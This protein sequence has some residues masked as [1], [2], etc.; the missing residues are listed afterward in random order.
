MSFFFDPDR[1]ILAQIN[2]QAMPL[3]DTDALIE[4]CRGKKFILIG[5]ATHGTAEFYRTRA[6]ITKTLIEA[7]LCDLVA[8]EADWPDAYRVNRYVCNRSDDPDGHEALADFERFPAWM[9]RNSEVL[10]FIEWLKA[11]NSILRPEEPC[12]FYG[13]D[14]YSMRASIG[15]VVRY[16]E[17][18]DP[19]EARAARQRY[20]CFGRFNNDPQSYGAAMASGVLDS[21]EQKALEQ[22]MEMQ[23]RAMKYLESDGYFANDDYFSAQQ[24][25]QIITKAEEYY[26]AMY[27]GQL[28]TWNLRDRHMFTTLKRITGFLGLK[29]EREMCTVVWAHNSH[30]GNAAATS[31]GRRGDFNIGQLVREQY[32]EDSI[33][34]GFS[35]STGTVTAAMEWDEPPETMELRSPIIGSYEELFSRAERRE[36]I[37]DLR[38]PALK[39]MLSEERMQRAIGVIYRPESERRSHYLSTSLPLQFDFMIHINETSALDPLPVFM[40][41]RM[42]DMDETYPTGL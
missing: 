8:V 5:E 22:V 30:L 35:T 24:N 13:L 29:A 27:R 28:N 40:H 19:E 32:P 34:I 21:C 18:V 37:L 36:F 7:G 14:L 15:A 20:S 23:R 31:M 1:K 11:Y 9:W 12:G 39:N 10:G 17:S 33:S 4:A 3:Y 2:A 16:L 38:E 25:A 41:P 6:D 26:R 42:G